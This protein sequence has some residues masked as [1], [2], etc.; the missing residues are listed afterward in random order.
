VGYNEELEQEQRQRA[1][2]DLRCRKVGTLMRII[3]ELSGMDLSVLEIETVL[4]TCGMNDDCAVKFGAFIRA[5]KEK[6]HSRPHR[7][8]HP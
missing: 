7:P 5:E 8:M 6:D 4:R 2:E 1:I 3:D